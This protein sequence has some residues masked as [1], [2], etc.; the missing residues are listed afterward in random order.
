MSSNYPRILFVASI[1]FN[2]VTLRRRYQRNIRNQ[3]RIQRREMIVRADT[4]SRITQMPPQITNI[5]FVNQL[6]NGSLFY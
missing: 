5:P 6:F 2:H 4:L 1:N 3:Q